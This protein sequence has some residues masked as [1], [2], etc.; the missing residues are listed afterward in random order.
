MRTRTIYFENWN[1]RNLV[2]FHAEPLVAIEIRPP[3]KVN[4]SAA[5]LLLQ[6]PIPGFTVGT[7]TKPLQLTTPWEIPADLQAPPAHNNPPR[8][9]CL[10]QLKPLTTAYLALVIQGPPN[11][12]KSTLALHLFASTFDYEKPS[13]LIWYSLLQ[14]AYLGDLLERLKT[15]ARPLASKPG[16][17]IPELIAW[18]YSENVVLVLDGLEEGN[19]QSFSPLLQ[20]CAR[21]PGPTRIIATSAVRLNGLT[22]FD[23]PPLSVEELI[24]L[25]KHLG[26]EVTEGDARKLI[27]KTEL[28]PY[29]VEKAVKQSGG[30]SSA[31]LLQAGQMHIQ[32]VINHLVQWT[33]GLFRF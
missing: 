26:A 6:E 13:Q 29:S 20:R 7:Y 8:Q 22:T 2:E 33:C 24:Q 14:G 11:S 21:L 17:D 23:V 4:H 19:I 32:E 3:T 12:G 15:I 16:Q 10:D 18:L 27:S 25:S 5:E 28:W 9:R 31:T 1:R 30:V